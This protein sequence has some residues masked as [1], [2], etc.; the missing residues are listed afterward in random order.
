MEIALGDLKMKVLTDLQVCFIVM[1]SR[2][3]SP[4]QVSNQ[5]RHKIGVSERPQFHHKDPEMWSEDAVC[6]TSVLD[7]LNVDTVLCCSS[8]HF[9]FTPFKR[10]D[11]EYFRDECQLMII[12]EVSQ[13]TQSDCSYSI[14]NN[15]ETIN[16]YVLYFLLCNILCI[17]S[18]SSSDGFSSMPVLALRG[19][20]LATVDWRVPSLLLTKN[21]GTAEQD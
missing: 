13:T 18:F 14:L 5:Y 15:L 20:Q 9:R 21:Q 4:V 7:I 19:K 8:I 2:V 12:D 16:Q 1:G 3:F 17:S 6:G 10:D 11:L